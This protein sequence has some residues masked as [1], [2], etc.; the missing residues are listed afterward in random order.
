MNKFVEW[1]NWVHLML[2]PWEIIDLIFALQTVGLLIGLPVYHTAKISELNHTTNWNN[3][4]MLMIIIV[5]AV[6]LSSN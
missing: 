6:Q 1:W 2:F 5:K 4:M 3:L